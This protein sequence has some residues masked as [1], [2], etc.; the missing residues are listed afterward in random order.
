MNP[1]FD[2]WSGFFSQALDFQLDRSIQVSSKHLKIKILETKRVF[3][4]QVLSPLY[5]FQSG[6]L[7][8]G[9]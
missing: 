5:H 9:G 6:N 4:P 2:L 1:E 8:S 3:S 7:I